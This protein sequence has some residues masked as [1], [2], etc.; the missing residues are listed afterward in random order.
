M[1]NTINTIQ[2]FLELLQVAVG[3]RQALSRIPNESEWND[4]HEMA[5]KQA[6]IGV[7]FYALKQ[8]PREQQPESFFLRKWGAQTLVVASKNADVSKYCRLLSNNLK[9]NGFDV[10][11]LKGQGNCYYYPEGLKEFRQ[12]GDID[13]WAW[14]APATGEQA[15]DYKNP[16]KSLIEFCQSVTKGEYVYYHNM[17]FPVFKNV[18]V[19]MHYRPSW[20]FCPWR[21]RI[22]QTWFTNQRNMPNPCG[23]M[24]YDG[25]WIPGP[26][27]NVV[28]QLLHIYKHIFEEGIGLRQ[29]L[30]YYCVLTSWDKSSQEEIIKLLKKLGMINFTGAV[31]YVLHE[32]FRINERDMLCTPSEKEGRELLDEIL[33]AGNFGHYDSRYNFGEVTNGSM[34]F[35]GMGYAWMRLKRNL[36]FVW[37]Y[38][39]E[40]LFEPPFRIVHWSWRTFKLWRY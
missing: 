34:Q 40:V 25:Y 9:K 32:V 14:P 6:L 31:M 10:V 36:R 22:L 15:K 17:D 35:R 30:D 37:S 20:L 38:P 5:K 4:I 18:P 26:K 3:N 1:D 13:A 29:L 7:C 19:E 33:I 12:P 21:N 2:L 24:E 11:I 23:G 16:V 28:F 39:L 27:F 8:L